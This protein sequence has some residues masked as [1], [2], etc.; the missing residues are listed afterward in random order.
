MK[1]GVPSEV[2]NHEYRVAVT[3]AGVHEL[4]RA[5]HE[6]FIQ[7]G[8]GDG[9]SLDDEAYVQVGATIVPNADEGAG[10][11]GEEEP[12]RL[13]PRFPLPHVEVGP[14]P[15]ALFGVPGEGAVVQRDPCILVLTD[16]EG[17]DGNPVGKPRFADR[18]LQRAAHLPERAGP[19]EASFRGEPGRAGQVAVGPDLQ[20]RTSRRV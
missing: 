10:S 6:V 18:L 7:K 17:P 9:S 20:P 5:G 3:P 11:L 15:R 12:V 1:V 19:V 8:A 14:G 4:T 13:E 2:K 16:A